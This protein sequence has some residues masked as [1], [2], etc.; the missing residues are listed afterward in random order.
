MAYR[1]HR[2][3]KRLQLCSAHR[4][5][6]RELRQG[7][8]RGGYKAHVETADLLKGALLPTLQTHLDH[9]AKMR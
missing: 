3:G 4:F 5:S 7:L 6:N 9:I 2:C 8:H 1:H